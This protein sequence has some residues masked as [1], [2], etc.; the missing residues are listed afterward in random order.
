MVKFRTLWHFAVFRAIADLFSLLV[1][2]RIRAPATDYSGESSRASSSQLNPSPSSSSRSSAPSGGAA[3]AA[4]AGQAARDKPQVKSKCV[5]T[6]L[7][8]SLESYKK[9]IKLCV[10]VL[11]NLTYVLFLSSSSCRNRPHDGQNYQ[12]FQEQILSPIVWKRQNVF[13][14]FQLFLI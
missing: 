9:K 14:E 4:G 8:W 6:V 12:G 2:F 7:G 10:C 3:G 5:L 11:W 1:S 13:Y